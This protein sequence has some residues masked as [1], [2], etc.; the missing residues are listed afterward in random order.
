MAAGVAA[1]LAAG[2]GALPPLPCA[3]AGQSYLS[4]P[5][6]WKFVGPATYVNAPDKLRAEGLAPL[7]T[8]GDDD[9]ADDF[10][11]EDSVPHPGPAA[12]RGRT[13][14]R[15]H[16]RDDKD[17]RDDYD[18]G[19]DRD[20]FDD[21]RDKAVRSFAGTAD[22]GLASASATQ[23]VVEG[24][25]G[26]WF[27]G[28]VNGGVW[29]SKNISAALPH[30]EN[31][32]DG[33]PVRCSAIAAM[34]VSPHDRN[35]VLAGCGPS[36]SGELGRSQQVLIT[37]DWGGVMESR[38]GGD[39]WAMLDA[40][41]V[42]YYVTAF[43]FPSAD[44]MLVSAYSHFYN[45]SDGGVWRTTD[46]GRT[47]GRTL[48]RQVFNLLHDPKTDTVVASAANDDRRIVFRSP[49][50]GRSW[51]EWSAGAAFGNGVLPYYS[52]LSIS[53][54]GVVFLGA[55]AREASNLTQTSSAIWYRS[56][57]DTSGRWTKVGGQPINL[58]QDLMAKDRM[59]VLVDPKEPSILYVAGNAAAVVYRV[60]WAAGSWEKA[61]GSEASGTTPHGD[62]RNF[63]WDSARDALLLTSDGGVFARLQ[64]RAPGGVWVSLGGDIRAMEIVQA[65]W[66]ARLSRWV[67]GAQ[68][69]G[70]QLSP[71]QA[72][73]QQAV[74]ILGGDGCLAEVDNQQEPSRIW[75]SIYHLTGLG[76]YEG[77]GAEARAVTLPLGKFF[78]DP[79]NVG[80]YSSRFPFF[81]SAF[82]LNTQRPSEVV[83]WARGYGGNAS[84]WYGIEVP[85]ATKSADDIP[86]PAKIVDSDGGDIYA[87]V[88]GGHTHDKPDP[89]VI[90]GV[91]DTSFFYRSAATNGKLMVRKLPATFARPVVGIFASGLGPQSHGKVAYVAVSPADSRVAAVTGWS[92]TDTNNVGKDGVWITHDAGETWMDVFGDL[93]EASCTVARA[94]PQGLLFV[95]FPE[96][97]ASALL[98]GTGSG[99][100][101]S[102][103]DRPGRWSRLGQCADLPLVMVTALTYEGYSDTLVAAT[104]GR[105][106]YVI[107][108]ARSALAAA[109]SQQMSGRCSAPASP[110][111]TPSD[112]FL[113]PRQ[114]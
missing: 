19:L 92:S 13:Q 1:L 25:P 5:A 11:L 14:H 30:W 6:E 69:N 18:R 83:V 47:F 33:Q 65:A 57:S 26:V 38:D 105:G 36:T 52:C 20:D 95:D 68:D 49:D 102:W 109:R 75:S 55:L 53:S 100:F 81:V 24:P 58:D 63:A 89:S 76:F 71:P 2:A 10:S 37:G 48:G 29:R 101:L 104:Y 32:L 43:A 34:A 67:G 41:P 15:H 8:F 22:K 86:W 72:D 90:V 39:T 45:E 97:K 54:G 51:A 44:S 21:A 4:C 59:A 35:R 98:V 82:T 50:H 46:G 94:R 114:A 93:A 106:V 17:D 23:L 79:L 31:V 80:T 7:R 99:V 3:T 87:F 28:T 12:R 70:V 85:R 77:S 61:W 66:D 78:P 91:N 96:F 110:L 113:P 73:G 64:P 16:D 108:K 62:C 107:H 112:Y 56:I 88:A 84:A 9:D 111:L 42:N 74:S 103:T 27:A 40:F 60:R